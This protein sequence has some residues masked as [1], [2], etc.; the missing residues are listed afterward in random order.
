MGDNIDFVVTDKDWNNDFKKVA[1]LKNAIT[2]NSSILH[3]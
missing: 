1:Y 2:V 3:A